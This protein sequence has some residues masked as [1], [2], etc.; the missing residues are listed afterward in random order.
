VVY[1]PSIN[2]QRVN[3]LKLFG[4]R[5]YFLIFGHAL[6]QYQPCGVPLPVFE[7]LDIA[8]A[9][10]RSD[11]PG[12][13]LVYLEILGHGLDRRVLFAPT[14]YNVMDGLYGLA[15]GL[16]HRRLD[17]LGDQAG[18]EFADAGV[19]GQRGY[20][21]TVLIPLARCLVE[22]GVCLD[23]A[24][25][26]KEVSSQAYGHV[27]HLFGQRASIRARYSVLPGFEP[28]LECMPASTVGFLDSPVRERPEHPAR[29]LT[30]IRNGQG[31]VARLVL[32]M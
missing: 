18:D 10:G 31:E 22:D 26:H 28:G 14:V 6:C 25:D 19:V 23:E 27:A 30:G 15:D 17:A 2:G 29:L 4:G 9:N 21:T 3:T 32:G 13:G 11:A 12:G 1:P 16:G 24:Q 8:S 20:D 7:V 5:E